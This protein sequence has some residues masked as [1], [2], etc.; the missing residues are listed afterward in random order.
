MSKLKRLP[1]PK[2]WPI[3]RKTKKYVIS[4]K[5]GPH[6][7]EKCI[8]LGLIIRDVLKHAET[9]KEVK[10]ILNDNKVKVDGK[11]IRDYRF[12][13]GLMDVVAVGDENYRILI[14]KK[15]LYLKNISESESKIKLL[16][17]KN[18]TALKKGKIQINF[19]DGTNKL[20]AGD[21][22]LSKIKTGDSVLIDI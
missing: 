1:S 4:P 5:P 12:P 15:G 19:H 10:T 13:V 16:V 11:I 7:S 6:S 14:N 20:V 8:P 3:E 22:K 17:I 18:K 9:L 21:D 2:W